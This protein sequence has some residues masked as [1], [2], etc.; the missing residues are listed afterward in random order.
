M[1]NGTLTFVQIVTGTVRDRVTLFGL[2]TN[3]EVYE[4]NST[5]EGWIPLPM[6]ALQP[7]EGRSGA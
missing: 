3:G 4:Y 7:P 1:T 2:A 6:V 5:R